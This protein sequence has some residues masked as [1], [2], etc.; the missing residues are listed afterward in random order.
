MS[1][2]LLEIRD[3]HVEL[4]GNPVLKGVDARLARG[5]VSALIGLNGSGKSTLLRALVKEVPYTGRVVFHCGHDHSRP[6]PE[7]VGYVPQKLRIEANLP[8]TVYDLFGLAMNRRPLFLGVGR[9]V[10]ERMREMLARVK[11]ED[12]LH[13]PV[14]KLSGGQLQRVLL[15]LALEPRPELLLLDEPA[16]GIDFREEDKFYDLIADLNRHTGVTILLVSHD[17]SVV[18]RLAH[19]VLCLEDGRIQCQGAP[20]EIVNDEVIARIFGA[21]KAVYA[22]THPHPHG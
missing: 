10:R 17:L 12:L 2:D 5:G 7:H 21:G 8:L 22:H 15:A 20:R 13:R 9:R 3:L 18:S 19:H 11:A 14:E 16:A 6:T 1:D 4:G